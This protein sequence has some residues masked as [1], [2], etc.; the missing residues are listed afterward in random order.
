MTVA[1]CPVI[2][3]VF[4]LLSNTTESNLFKSDAWILYM[5]SCFFPWAMA[6]ELDAE[7]ASESEDVPISQQPLP[8]DAVYGPM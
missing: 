5:W 8:N 7:F 4:I 3:L 2:V 6:T 1:I